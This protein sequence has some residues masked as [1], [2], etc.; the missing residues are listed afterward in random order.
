MDD[1]IVNFIAGLRAAGV[2]VSVA[3]SVDALRAIEQAG[4]QD[5]DLFR[6]ALQT[7]LVKDPQA[8]PAFQRLFPL[9]FGS[10]APPMQQPGGGGSM[11]EE[12]QQ[13][14]QQMLQ[15][16]LAEMS[17]EQLAQ[18]FEAMM[19]GQQPTNEAIREMLGQLPLPPMTHPYYQE[20][21]TRRA[22]RQMQF[23]KLD[24]ALQELLE[25]LREAGMSEEALQEIAEAAQQNQQ[26]LAEQIARQVGQQM[27]EQAQAEGMRP[28]SIDQLMDRPFEHLTPD[29]TK[30]LRT[31]VNRLAA[32]LR[33]RMALR[34]RRG[35]SG[36]LDAKGTIRTNL[37]FGGVP[38][39][40]RHRRRHLK[41]RLVVICDLSISMR[42]VAGFML[43]L[44]YA[45]Q[46]QISRTRS[47]AFI[48]DLHDVSVDF[49][50]CRTERAIE[51]IQERIRPPRSYATDLGNSLGTF[52]QDYCGCVDHRTTVIVLGDA[53]NN[54]N[55]PNLEAFSQIRRRAR[56][57]VWFNPEPPAMWGRY[58][59]GSLSSDMLKYMPM[60]DSVH[61][62]ST[63]RDLAA[64]IDHLFTRRG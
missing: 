21:M 44:I 39:I 55:D 28:Q 16:M 45:L 34:Q 62:V 58:D 11:S 35:K 2:R 15:Q 64:A 40:V 1:R 19:R 50:Q 59:P 52:V 6:A 17:P 43:L 24:Q 47:F 51:Q 20:W 4:I 42:P 41:P 25:Q 54:E 26:A 53:R 48:D 22:M 14:F 30:D 38:L 37:R 13:M 3:E 9:Y 32:R 5:K 60:C 46:D 33:S 23:A 27:I 63:M 61:H 8:V 7:T 31:L 29:E 18:L 56:R 36:T 10:D 57:V 12:E 49:A